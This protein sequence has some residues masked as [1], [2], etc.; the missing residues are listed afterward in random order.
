MEAEAGPAIAIT[1]TAAPRKAI[2]RLLFITK[3]NYPFTALD[4]LG[5]AQLRVFL[6]STQMANRN[7]LISDLYFRFTDAKKGGLQPAKRRACW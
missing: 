4:S 7:T 6:L 1:P 5:P 2:S 3:F